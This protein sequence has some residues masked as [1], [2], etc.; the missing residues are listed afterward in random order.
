MNASLQASVLFLRLRDLAAQAPAEQRRRRNGLAATARIAAAAWPDDARLVLEAPEGLAIVGRGAA[1]VALE[2][3]R[4]AGA[5]ST[6]PA[7]GFALHHGPV[8]VIEGSTGAPRL[9]G[10]GLETAAALAAHASGGSVLASAAFHEAVTA[11]SPQ[12]GQAFRPAGDF[13]DARQQTQSL[14]AVDPAAARRR[15]QRRSLLGLAAVAGLLG[16][17][18]AA[19]LVRERIEAARRPAI[20]VL[21]IRPS[22][23]VYVDGVFQGSTPPLDRL[24][25]PAG[26]HAIEIR[27][28]RAKPLQL[29]VQLQPGEEMQLRHVFPPPPPPPSRRSSRRPSLLD[30]LKDGFNDL[31]RP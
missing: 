12:D 18:V 1:S 26:E 5:A 27:H 11:Q 25:L 3:A 7:L 13:A 8:G 22:G 10:E 31:V 14:F 2:A 23:E 28:E 21:D 15:V 29:R 20:L 19:R 9:A 16:A 30:R 6:D 24:S 17:G 4:R